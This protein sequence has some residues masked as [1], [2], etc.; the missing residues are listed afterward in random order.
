MGK[1]WSEELPKGETLIAY[2]DGSSTESDSGSGV[3][4]INLDKDEVSIAIKLDFP[5]TN[6]KAEYE[7][8]LAGLGIAKDL[9]ARNL[10]IHSDSQVVVGHVQGGFEANTEKMI[11]FL[12]KVHNLRDQFDQ[13]MITQ[14][15]RADNTRA[16]SLAWLGLGPNKDIEASKQKVIFLS[17]PSIAVPELI[18]QIEDIYDSP[19]WAKDV[20]EYLWK[21]TLPEDKKEA[22]KVRAQSAR[23]T[24][25]RMRIER[26]DYKRDEI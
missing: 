4:L 9:G 23:Y 8:V 19:D 21:G 17:L 10:K 12:A 6:N 14:I 18:M 16:D 1:H 20:I 3:F 15:P 25:V 26:D 7:A 13:M 24:L 5:K 2:V 11:K 22:W